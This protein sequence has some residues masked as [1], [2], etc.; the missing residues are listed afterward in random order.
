MRSRPHSRNLLSARAI[1]CGACRCGGPMTSCLNQKRPTSTMSHPA[2]SADRL[3][4]GCFCAGSSVR[5]K[6]GCISISTPGIRRASPVGRKGASVRG[7]ARSIPCWLTALAEQ[8][9]AGTSEPLD[10]RVTPAR[11]DLAAKHLAGKVKAARFVEGRVCEVIEPQAPLRRAPSPDAPL[12]TEAL[13][14]ERVTVYEAT[15]EGWAWIQ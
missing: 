13:K 8:G 6:P 4:L 14:G 11:A 5:P 3:L 15:D 7:R 12:E 1:R 9:H 2:I 10:P